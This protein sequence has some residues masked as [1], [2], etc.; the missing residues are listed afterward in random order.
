MWAKLAGKGLT[1][2]VDVELGEHRGGSAK[3]CVGNGQGTA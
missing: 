2:S 3:A 1:E